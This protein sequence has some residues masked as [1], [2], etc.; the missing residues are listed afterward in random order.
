[1]SSKNDMRL[2]VFIAA[3]GIVILLGKL[4]VFGFLGRVLWPLVILVPGLFLQVLFFS[5]R[6]SAAVL[7]PAGILTVWGLLFGFCNTWG[8]GYMS[9]LWPL[10]LFGIAA[11]LY[12]YSM[13]ASARTG[14][15]MTSSVIL[16]VLSLLLLIFSLLGTG[17]LYLLAAVLIAAGIWLIAGRGKPG[18]A[19]KWN[20][21]W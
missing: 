4:G 5:R 14:G 11:G 1:M 21:G 8:W 17:A 9:H 19:K 3:A 20:G 6:A 16:G 15:L 2:G 18:S 13:F 12:E 10:L 7:V